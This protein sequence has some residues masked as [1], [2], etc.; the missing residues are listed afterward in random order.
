M[1]CLKK[2]MREDAFLSCKVP[3]IF[4]LM[5][6]GCSGYGVFRQ[7]KAVAGMR[8]GHVPRWSFRFK[9]HFACM[10]MMEKHR[11]TC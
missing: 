9:G 7:E 11:P 1:H 5:C 4:L 2:K 6:R 8:T 3:E 10:W